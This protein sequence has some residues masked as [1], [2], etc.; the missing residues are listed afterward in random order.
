[1]ET[2]WHGDIVTWRPGGVQEAWRHGGI[3][4][5]RQGMELRKLVLW[6]LKKQGGESLPSYLLATQI[7]HQ[8]APNPYP[9]STVQKCCYKHIATTYYATTIPFLEG[10]LSR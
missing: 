3:E 9:T 10:H 7:S 6:A 2:Q 5:S 1:M 4:R 8:T